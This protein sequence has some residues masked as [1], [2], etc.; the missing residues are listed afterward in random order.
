LKPCQLQVDR[1]AVEQKVLAQ[2]HK[3]I[4]LLSDSGE[5]RQV[6]RETLDGP[7]R[8]SIWALPQLSK[9]S[10]VSQHSRRRSQQH[11]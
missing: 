3:W 8:T 4:E 10:L 11:S 7:I 1:Q 5:R 9:R 6:L 2:V